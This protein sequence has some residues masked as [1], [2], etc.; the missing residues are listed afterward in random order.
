MSVLSEHRRT[1]K[2]D[3]RRRCVADVNRNGT[4]EWDDFQLLIEIIGDSRGQGS[5]EYLSAKLVLNEIWHKLISAIGKHD[6]K[7]IFYAF[8]LNQSYCT[9]IIDTGILRTVYFGI[10]T[11]SIVDSF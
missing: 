11:S 3:V 6:D 7:V 5:E 8:F 4:L 10:E 2:V 1:A 9:G